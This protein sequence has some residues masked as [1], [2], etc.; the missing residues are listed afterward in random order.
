MNYAFCSAE[1]VTHKTESFRKEVDEVLF[2]V[3]SYA[4]HRKR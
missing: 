4:A 1:A 2:L 3:L